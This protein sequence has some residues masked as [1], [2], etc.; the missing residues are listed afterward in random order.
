MICSDSLGGIIIASDLDRLAT[1]NAYVDVG[2]TRRHK[3]KYFSNF[4]QKELKAL[5]FW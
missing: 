4:N 3:H 5:P 1:G 2:G